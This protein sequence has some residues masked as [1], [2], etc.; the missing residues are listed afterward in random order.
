M[1]DY[2]FPD[3]VI[4]SH[5]SCHVDDEDHE[6]PIDPPVRVHAGQRV[7]IGVFQDKAYV[8][9]DPELLEAWHDGQAQV[10]GGHP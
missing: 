6:Y 4:I 9:L 1:H 5:V 2:I 3:D 8:E 7:R 10:Q